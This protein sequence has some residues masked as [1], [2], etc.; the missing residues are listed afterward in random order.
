M[1]QFTV[2]AGHL[3]DFV[4][5]R[6]MLIKP[7]R[8]MSPSSAL[9]RSKEKNFLYRMATLKIETKWKMFSKYRPQHTQQKLTPLVIRLAN[10]NW[11]VVVAQTL[12]FRMVKTA[13]LYLV[14]VKGY[15]KN[16]HPYLILKRVLDLAVTHMQDNTVT[17]LWNSCPWSWP[18]FLFSARRIMLSYSN[19]HD[20]VIKNIRAQCWLEITFVM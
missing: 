14:P 1:T 18:E 11:H 2:V 12:L 6:K 10:G 15:S 4:A 3:A 13:G 7:E 17:I 8:N 19:N 9:S 20:F 5:L 16:G